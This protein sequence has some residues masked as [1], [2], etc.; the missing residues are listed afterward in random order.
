MILKE[1]IADLTAD[2]IIS[3]NP[4]LKQA[5][6]GETK[7]K[8]WLVEYVGEK[9]NNELVT[10]EMIVETVSKEFPEFLLAVA[11][12]NWVRGYHQALSD[13]DEGTK[14]ANEE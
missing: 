4:V 1:K 14:I 3:D 6:M 7:L 2:E 11:E 12:E 9:N 8:T 5:V 13:V 10:V